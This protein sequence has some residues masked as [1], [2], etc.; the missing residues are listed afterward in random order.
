MWYFEVCVEIWW[1]GGREIE[2]IAAF[3]VTSDSYVRSPAGL[4][5]TLRMSRI[6]GHAEATR[7]SLEAVNKKLDTTTAGHGDRLTSELLSG[8]GMGSLASSARVIGNASMSAQR[9]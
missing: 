4:G 1:F 5:I 3:C 7:I 9:V 2:S 8:A 6:E